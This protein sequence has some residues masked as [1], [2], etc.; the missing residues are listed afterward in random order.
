MNTQASIQLQQIEGAARRD[1]HA[2]AEICG[3]R[4][5]CRMRAQSRNGRRVESTYYEMDGRRVKFQ[6]VYDTVQAA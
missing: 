3:H 5:V 2:T 6:Q 1:G 4:V